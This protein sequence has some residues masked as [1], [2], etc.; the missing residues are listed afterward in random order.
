MATTDLSAGVAR[1]RSSA[2]PTRSTWELIQLSLFWIAV[3]FHWTIL[4]AIILPQQV[5]AILFANHP[6]GLSGAA[7]AS[8][9]ANTKPGALAFVEGPGLLVALLSNPLFGWLSDRTRLRWGRRKPYILGGTLV[10]I[11]GLGIMALAPNLY[12]LVGGLMLTQLGNNA[13]AAP[14][15]ALLPDLVPALQRGKA[16]GY[17]GVG[18]MVGTI[19]GAEAAALF[20]HIDVS[21]LVNGT[22]SFA[23]YQHN[24][25]AIYGFI[26]VFISVFALLTVLVVREL[27]PAARLD[28]P[29]A[30]GMRSRGDLLRDLLATIGGIIIATALTIGALTLLH[31]NYQTDQNAA[32]IF[33]LP[34]LIIGSLG[35]ARAFDFRPRQSPDFAWVLATR[36]L[37]MLGIYTVFGFLQYYLQDVTLHGTA[38]P[39]KGAVAASGNFLAIV[40]GTAAISTGF[41]G[42]LSDRFGRKRMVYIAGGF[43]ALV[44]A[45]FIVLSLLF[46]SVESILYVCAAIFGLGYGSYISVDWALVT[47]VLPSEENYARDMGVWN[48]AL[49]APQVIAYILGAYAIV[50]FNQGGVFAIGGQPHFGYTMLFVLLVLYAVLG[51]VTVRYI[52]GIKR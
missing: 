18:Q 34:A 48:I 36:S 49:T 31:L 6:A 4:P 44:G 8:Y 45:L 5:Q 19:V 50:A 38:D 40:I 15:H 21:G 16:A 43:M 14:F 26:A 7:L 33:V 22:Q 51:T 35:V 46:P 27:P 42:Y 32:N 23:A 9:V 39:A 10:N 41:A 24:L 2:L 28:M 29:T 37:V 52:K 17:M 1:G 30:A 47:D 13:A 20:F 3:N 25:V 11:A 12:V